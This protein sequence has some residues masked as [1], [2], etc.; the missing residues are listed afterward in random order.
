L[1]DNQRIGSRA[2]HVLD[3]SEFRQPGG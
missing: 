3:A 1:V 2:L